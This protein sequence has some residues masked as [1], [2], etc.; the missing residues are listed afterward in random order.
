MALIVATIGVQVPAGAQEP[1]PAPPPGTDPAQPGADDSGPLDLYTGAMTSEQAKQ[2]ADGG[3]DIV[4]TE[5]SAD[6]TNVDVQAVLSQDELARVEAR[7]GVDMQLKLNANGQSSAEAAALQAASGFNVWRSWD[8]AGGIR[9]EMNQI[10]ADNPNI[11]KR[12]VLA[13]TYQGREILALKVT[14]GANRGRDGHK[15]AVLYVS[16]QHARE[17]ISVEVNRRLLNWYIDHYNAGDPAIRD[18]LQTTELWFVLSANPDGYQYTFDAERLWRKNLRD[19]NSDGQITIGDGVDPNR[20]WPE[21]FNY[22]GEGSSA[23]IANDTYRGPSAT[24]EPETQ[25]LKGLIDRVKPKTMSNFHSF[26]PLILYPQGWIVGA[27]DADNPIYAALAGTD[28]NPAIPGFDPGV[29]A[30]ELYVTNG[31]TTDYA[32]V[33]AGTLAFTPE[34]G[35][36]IPGAGFVFPDDEALIQAEFEKTL[37]FD[38]GLA[39]S[40]QDP[41]HPAS[42]VGIV[43]KPF[44]LDQAEIDPENGPSTM[45]DYSFDTS[46]GDNQEVR[47]LALRSLGSVQV[48]YRINGGRIHTK[49]TEEWTGGERYGVGNPNYYRVKKGFVTGTHAGDS[50]EVWF[51]GGGQSSES[52]TYTVASDTGNRVLV[53]SAEDYTGAS[54]VYANQTSPTFLHFYTDALN[55]NGVGFDVYDVDAHGRVAPD[56]LGVLSHYDAVIWYTGDDLITR[57]AGWAGGNADSLAMT[58]LLGIRDFINEGGRVL[59]TGK[60]A[61]HQ[62]GPGHGT[63]LYDP[64]ENAQCRADPAIQARC[65]GLNGSGDFVGDVLQ[66]WFGA[67]IL[68]EDAGT[69][70]A[71]G[72]LFNVSGTDDPFTGMDWGFNGAD[73]GQN[74]DHSASFITTSGL[75]PVADYPQFD[76]WVSS[77]YDRPGGPFDPHSGSQYV[78]SQV[79]DVSYKRLARTITV[80]AGGANLSFF[81]SHDTELEWDHFLVEAHTPGQDDWTTLPDLNGHTTQS[82]GQSCPAAWNTLHP[83]L[84]HYQTLDSAAGTCTPTG[85]TGEWNASSGSSAGWQ[86]WS[87]D[88]SPYAA[89]GQVEVSLTYIS[90]F[91]TQGL[92]VFIDDIAVSTGEGSTDFEADMAG[93]SAPGAPAGS[94]PNL[95]DFARITGANLPEGAV[96]ATPSTLYMGFGFE[97]ISDAATRVAVMGKAV[98]YLLR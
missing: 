97:G 93:W 74:Q 56:P 70:F 90:D 77:R 61:G 13:T 50:V 16:N 2:L 38:L 5:P 29:S 60:A 15:P 88:L 30:D 81:V 66:Y 22:D 83:F 33:N 35:E 43:T 91:A 23:I 57:K 84:D 67:G 51:A 19:N 87:V 69:D 96:V 40:A 11:V 86:Q 44:Y 25:A 47:V 39:R 79:A 59:Y 73:S 9:D 24:S 72:N 63:Q 45:F 55:A 92:G 46:Y 58:E 89:A 94:A 10:A 32:D 65:R 53:L 42:P 62:Y 85:T 7:T 21:H 52:F 12:E 26:G 54:P 34:L 28:A 8:E 27:P 4:A 98:E 3:L 71:N 49:R 82:T 41:A 1:D 20:N 64:F 36:G 48:K 31:E 78:Y 6:G 75:L 76:S 37:N 80:P 95:N 68:V 14:T 17:W 18:L